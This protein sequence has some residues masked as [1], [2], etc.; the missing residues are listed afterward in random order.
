MNTIQV[1]INTTPSSTGQ[2]NTHIA[3][4]SPASRKTDT[5][6][7]SQA[8]AMP[9]DTVDSPKNTR[10]IPVP[11]D[12][13]LLAQFDYDKEAHQLIIRL[14]RGDTGEVVQQIPPEHIIDFLK[15]VMKQVGA[16]IDAKG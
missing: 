9:T 5:V 3:T 13:Q 1:P 16:L 8:P 15:S 12:P 6:I 14:K 10:Q 4:D 7:P 2:R 11:S